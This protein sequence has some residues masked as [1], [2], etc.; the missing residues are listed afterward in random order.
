LRLTEVHSESI[1]ADLLRINNIGAGMVV[2]DLADHVMR[3]AGDQI[4]QETTPG[5]LINS[6]WLLVLR[7]CYHGRGSG[8][9]SEEGRKGGGR[10]M[11]L[12]C[13]G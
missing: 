10:E 1:N 13:K 3:K 12:G 8:N 11:H 5:V 2:K 6:H 4:S 9:T 7:T